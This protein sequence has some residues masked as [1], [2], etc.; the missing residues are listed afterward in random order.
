M[1]ST[2]L[3]PSSPKCNG[4]ILITLDCLF[5]IL[6]FVETSP[7]GFARLVELRIG[8]KLL[9]INIFLKKRLKIF[10]KKGFEPVFLGNLVLGGPIGML[11]DVCTGAVYKL[12]PQNN[13]LLLKPNEP[14][15]F[16]KKNPSLPRQ[17]ETE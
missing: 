12:S 9:N 17:E 10:I 11:V 7:R 13:F 15:S 16:I 8:L 5:K 6:N 4:Y 2:R 1:R 3:I 14:K